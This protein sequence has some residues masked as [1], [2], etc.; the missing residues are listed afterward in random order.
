MTT[1]FKEFAMRLIQYLALT[2]LAL[3]AVAC[4]QQPGFDSPEG[5]MMLAQSAIAA[6]QFDAFEQTL[7]SEAYVDFGDIH[8]TG[9]HRPFEGLRRE[10]AS[11]PD[12][13][14]SEPEM[15]GMSQVSWVRIKHYNVN[16]TDAL[17]SVDGSPFARLRVDCELRPVGGFNYQT[18][19][20]CRIGKIELR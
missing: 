14:V 11:H 1:A 8:R 15:A 3:S 17:R 12:A 16:L 4:T 9:D 2:I 7:T 20:Y 10:A 18:R 13:K 19:S 5:V 6:D